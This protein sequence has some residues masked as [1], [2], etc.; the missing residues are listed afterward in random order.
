MQYIGIDPGQTGGIAIIDEHGVT[1]EVMPVRDK[2][3]DV[4]EIVP[5]FAGMSDPLC[6][7]E[8]VGAMPK[9]GVSST[10]KFGKGFGKLLGMLEAIEIPY[11][12]VTPQ[13]WKKTVLVGMN[14]K[15]RK[16]ASIEYCRTRYPKLDLKASPRC[17]KDHDG[18]ADAL[19]M[20]EYGR[21]YNS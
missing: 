3:I 2:E 18:M 12:L 11:I 4:P 16:V 6:V 15:G 19:C 13:Q 8:K 7:I 17:R 21:L 1:A 5:Y 9:Q 10:F 20:A 14:W